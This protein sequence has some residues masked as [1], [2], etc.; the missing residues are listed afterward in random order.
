MLMKTKESRG[1]NPSLGSLELL[2]TIIS[3]SVSQNFWMNISLILF[4]PL[5]FYIETTCEASNLFFFLRYFISNFKLRDT[6]CI[7]V[8]ETEIAMR[9]MYVS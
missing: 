5:Q 1:L 4:V 2:S 9:I 6:C 8:L 3:W 7:L